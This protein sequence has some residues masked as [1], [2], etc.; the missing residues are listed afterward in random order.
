MVDSQT[1]QADSAVI[2]LHWDVEDSALLCELLT[3]YSGLEQRMFI[4]AP[5]LLIRSHL[6]FAEAHADEAARE[7]C[8]YMHYGPNR[9]WIA[10]LCGQVPQ[11]EY[12]ARAANLCR[13]RL[14][15]GSPGQWTHALAD[16]PFAVAADSMQ[17]LVQSGNPDI[18]QELC[19]STSVSLA[20]LPKF[21]W[22]HLIDRAVALGDQLFS[23]R[24]VLRPFSVMLASA[25]TNE[26]ADFAPRLTPLRTQ[27]GRQ[28]VEIPLDSDKN[29]HIY[30]AAALLTAEEPAVRKHAEDFVLAHPEEAVNLLCYLTRS[31]SPF[32][33]RLLEAICQGDVLNML[34]SHIDEIRSLAQDPTRLGWLHDQ[35]ATL[36]LQ[37]SREA[38]LLGSALGIPEFRQKAWEVASSASVK[39]ESLKFIQSLAAGGDADAMTVLILFNR[40][41]HSV[42]Q[43]SSGKLSD[44]DADCLAL[45]A[46]GGQMASSL[47]LSQPP[48]SSLLHWQS[49]LENISYFRGIPDDGAAFNL[50]R[51]MLFTMTGLCQAGAVPGDF[52]IQASSRAMSYMTEY[53]LPLD[54]TD[55]EIT[56]L[57]S[58]WYGFA[59][60]LDVINISYFAPRPDNENGSG[61]ADDQQQ[62]ADQLQADIQ[63]ADALAKE[64]RLSEAILIMQNIVAYFG[65]VPFDGMDRV[66]LLGSVHYRLARF[67]AQLAY[68]EHD[69][70]GMPANQIPVDDALRNAITHFSTARGCAE[71]SGDEKLGSLVASLAQQ[72]REAGA[73]K[74]EE[75]QPP[76]ND[77]VDQSAQDIQ[78]I[79]R[80]SINTINALIDACKFTEALSLARDMVQKSGSTPPTI[81]GFAHHNLAVTVLSACQYYFDGSGQQQPNHLE[82]QISWFLLLDEGQQA[83]ERAVALMP[84][85]ENAQGCRDALA[86]APRTG[87]MTKLFNALLEAGDQRISLD[88]Y[89]G[90]IDYFDQTLD[91]LQ[92]AGNTNENWEGVAHFKIAKTIMNG[93]KTAA[94][95]ASGDEGLYKEQRERELNLME[96]MHALVP[97]GYQE[98]QLAAKLLPNDTA[99]QKALM[100][101]E[102]WKFNVPFLFETRGKA[103]HVPSTNAQQTPLVTRTEATAPARPPR[104]ERLGVMTEDDVRKNLA[105]H[106]MGAAD[107][108]VESVSRFLGFVRVVDTLLDMGNIGE[109]TLSIVKVRELATAVQQSGIS[110]GQWPELAYEIELI[111]KREN[112]LAA[113]APVETGWQQTA[114]TLFRQ[115]Q[116]LEAAREF[117]LAA[118]KAR[119]I[120]TTLPPDIDD[121]SFD[122][123]RT[124]LPRFIQEN[125]AIAWL[126][127]ALALPP[128]N[129]T[130]IRNSALAAIQC[131]KE[132]KLI[133]SGEKAQERQAKMDRVITGAEQVLSGLP[134]QQAQPPIAPIGHGVSTPTSSAAGV[135]VP[136]GQTAAMSDRKLIAGILGILLGALGVHRFYLGYT[137]IGIIQIVVTLVTCGWGALWGVVEGILIL[138]GNVITKDATGNP[139]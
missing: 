104:V 26:L 45:I 59:E 49:L 89:L 115:E 63:R 102:E 73:I 62:I 134:S 81:E 69:N 75:I 77:V 48:P 8:D 40:I 105:A 29:E 108:A 7:L 128:G 139:L 16:M 51:R 12:R 92:K 20:G 65:K 80:A 101:Y 111:A 93:S 72:L 109:A 34:H 39:G 33:V 122:Q 129:V 23:T 67:Y 88:D 121:P 50:V 31:H 54:W 64:G 22:P 138:T 86:N 19:W 82:E 25:S 118:T 30:L 27:L 58:F 10:S 32:V 100:L 136:T 131:A 11:P 38:V 98:A 2:K 97:R 110:A 4:R 66:S 35:L 9:A 53:L 119:Q 132:A 15:A 68:R 57:G 107:A 74:D 24:D 17:Q 43:E 94:E 133:I 137:T 42:M 52:D 99:A 127:A 70:E 60:A 117:D 84:S 37:N 47:W 1:E 61:W 46:I 14:L 55:P 13:E 87:S 112:V 21:L 79:V 85:Y 5:A 3:S 113:L 130:G 90:A 106:S 103:Q 96:R 124:N 18:V 56:S 78:D 114:T 116:F 135:S 6:P 123:L 36:S 44:E 126:K 83:A 95:W 71:Q 91:F 76:K 120:L 41:M 125:G 28:F